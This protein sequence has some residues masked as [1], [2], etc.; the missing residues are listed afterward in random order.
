MKVIV[1]GG[2]PKGATSVTMQYVNYIKKVIPEHE[3]EILQISSRIRKLERDMQAFSEV[4]EKVRSSDLVIWAFPLY[5]L[6]VPSQY[7]R[8][9]ELIWE[10]DAQDAFA[11]KYTA[12]ITTSIHFFDHTAHSYMHSICDDLEMNFAGFFSAD[13]HD[14]RELDGQNKTRQFGENVIDV[15]IRGISIPRQFPP[16]A[17][18]DF[19][20]SPGSVCEKI[21]THGKSVVVVHDAREG[22]NNLLRMI[23][24][25]KR[26]LGG[27]LKEYNL[28]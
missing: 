8:F 26:T 10:R 17:P 14:L 22:Q 11:D 13:M 24:Q 21:D 2:S 6:S 7:K 5:V 28:L 19:E 1:L 20:Y 9:I 15:A 27:D 16:V 18:V 4:I 23:E 12:V 3:Y 25:F